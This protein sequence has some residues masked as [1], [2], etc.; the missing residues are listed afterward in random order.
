M[1]SDKNKNHHPE[2]IYFITVEMIFALPVSFVIN[3]LNSN[4]TFYLNE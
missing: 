4:R 3:M 2:V 1:I